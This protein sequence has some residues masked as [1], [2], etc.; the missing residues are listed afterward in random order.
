MD[1]EYEW[2]LEPLDSNTNEIVA[3]VLPD[4]NFSE[5]V[6]CGDGKEHKLWACDWAFVFIMKESKGALGAKFRIFN[7]CG[8]GPIRE[9]KFLYQGKR[10]R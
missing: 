3:R 5:N 10:K 8:R 4:E 1:R 2:F 7:R 9:C 6:I